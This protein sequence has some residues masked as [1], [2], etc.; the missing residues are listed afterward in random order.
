MGGPGDRALGLAEVGRQAIRDTIR[1]NE[2]TTIGGIDFKKSIDERMRL[3]D[4]YAGDRP[5]KVYLNVGGGTLSVG[6]RLGKSLYKLGLNT[7]PPAGADQVNGIIPRFFERGVPV[8]HLVGFDRLAK[9]NGIVAASGGPTAIGIG[10]VYAVS[11]YNPWLAAGVLVAIMAGLK[12]FVL[13][14]APERIGN[15]IAKRT[16]PPAEPTVLA[17]RRPQSPSKTRRKPAIPA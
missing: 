7:E 9:R 2:L 13:S 5:I 12:F 11:K 14:D 16:R 17:I 4:Q 3:Y 6:R 15:A 10:D 1:R 8:V